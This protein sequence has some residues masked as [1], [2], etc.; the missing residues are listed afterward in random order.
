MKTELCDKCKS[1]E[2]EFNLNLDSFCDLDSVVWHL[3]KDCMLDLVDRISCNEDGVEI[4]TSTIS[5]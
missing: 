3:C 2:A 5:T 4:E 1:K